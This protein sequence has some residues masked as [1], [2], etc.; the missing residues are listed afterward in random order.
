MSFNNG[1][2]MCE[3][4]AVICFNNLMNHGDLAYGFED[5]NGARYFYSKALKISV[6][7][8]SDINYA[9]KAQ[10]KIDDCE[11]KIIESAYEKPAGQKKKG[12]FAKIREKL[13]G[14]GR[15]K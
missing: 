8:L 14:E 9:K 10:I 5:Y 1:V 12:V 13:S 4:E 11:E 15:G 3:G 7:Y 6:T 2:E